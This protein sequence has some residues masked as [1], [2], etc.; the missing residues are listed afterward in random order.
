MCA[1][2]QIPAIG[3]VGHRQRLV[4]RI[5]NVSNAVDDGRQGQRRDQGDQAN[6][7]RVLNH[8]LAASIPGKACKP[9]LT[10]QR[11]LPE[12]LGPDTHPFDT[13]CHYV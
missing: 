3:G 13:A 9:L 12:P 1:G 5:Q 7:Y 6:K 4:N 8:L 2:I 10:P 11:W